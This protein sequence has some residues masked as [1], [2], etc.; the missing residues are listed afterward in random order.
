VQKL[1]EP[2][3]TLKDLRKVADDLGDDVL[4][5]SMTNLENIAA[6]EILSVELKGQPLNYDEIWQRSFPVVD[7]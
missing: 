2:F 1:R 4:K 3:N 7:G 5:Q 6:A